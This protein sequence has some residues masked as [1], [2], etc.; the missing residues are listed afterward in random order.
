MLRSGVVFYWRTICGC[1]V[2]GIHTKEKKYTM[3]IKNAP[4]V[5]L[6]FSA[7]SLAFADRQVLCVCM[8]VCL[9][10]NFPWNGLWEP[11]QPCSML[12]GAWGG[13]CCD[14]WAA[15]VCFANQAWGMSPI[16]MVTADIRREGLQK[17][18]G[19]GGWGGQGDY[20]IVLHSDFP[21]GSPA[22][23]DL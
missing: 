3:D 11:P 15:L 8:C 5:C 20:C 17:G 9:Q 23:W 21:E 12:R 1:L 6:C 18:D 10:L 16:T 19:V 2:S 7:E 22:Q 4:C 13:L 14:L